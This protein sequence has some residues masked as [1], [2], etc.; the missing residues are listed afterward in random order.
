M[1]K[2]NIQLYTRYPLANIFAYNGTTIVHYLLGGA[3]IILGYGPWIGYPAG[4]TYLIFS[5]AE[6]YV[7]MPLKVCPNCVYFTLNN[8]L[9]ISGLNVVS[10]RFSKKGVVRNFSN[11]AKGTFCPNNLYLASLAIPV[12]AMIPALILNFSLAVLVILFL[13]VGLLIFRFFIIFPRIACIHCRARNICPQA[14]SMFRD[15]K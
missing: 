8:S 12:I 4:I 5:F 1:S 3:G 10:R 14:Q 2:S 15:A 7:L 9:C 13:V 6:M 11:R